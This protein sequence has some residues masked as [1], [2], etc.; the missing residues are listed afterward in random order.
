MAIHPECLMFAS[1][2][3]T[4]TV[5]PVPLTIA[6]RVFGPSREGGFA[7]CPC[8]LNVPL[9]IRM[10]LEPLQIR[11]ILIL[12]FLHSFDFQVACCH[13]HKAEVLRVSWSKDGKLLAT[14]EAMQRSLLHASPRYHRA[15]LLLLL[16]FPG[17][18]LCP[19]PHDLSWCPPGSADGTV[20]IWQPKQTA[21]TSYDGII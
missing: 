12:C 15:L 3:S 8:C 18:S 20:R 10:I 4:L 21:S 11:M 17:N 13:G 19:L 5:L 6:Q 7:R 2:L 16:V 1:P 9:L 14:G